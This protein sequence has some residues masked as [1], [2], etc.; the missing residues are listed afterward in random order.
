[1][2]TSQKATDVVN[3]LENKD[4]KQTKAMFKTFSEHRSKENKEALGA[5]FSV[6]GFMQSWASSEGRRME[7]Q[8]ENMWEVEWME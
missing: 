7:A 4:P 2:C 1:M 6:F 5:K 8:Y 3:D